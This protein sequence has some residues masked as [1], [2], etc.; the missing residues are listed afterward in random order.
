VHGVADSVGT[1]KGAEL[2]TE[3]IH[4]DLFAQEDNLLA[5]FDADAIVNAKGLGSSRLQATR[6]AI[7]LEVA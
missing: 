7:P 2:I 6:L 4:G 3:K 1:S 5:R